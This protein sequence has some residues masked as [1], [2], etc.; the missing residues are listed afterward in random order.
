[1]TLPILV[2]ETNRCSP[3]SAQ[4]GVGVL[5]SAKYVTALRSR[6]EGNWLKVHI[7]PLILLKGKVV[8]AIYSVE[9]IPQDCL[10][11][12]IKTG[13]LTFG[14]PKL[15]PSTS[16]KISALYKILILNQ[17]RRSSEAS[18]GIPDLT[19]SC[20]KEARAA[21]NLNGLIPI[22]FDLIIWGNDKKCDSSVEQITLHGQNAL[23]FQPGAVIA[24]RYTDSQALPKYMSL[25]ELGK[26]PP[27]NVEFIKLKSIR[28]MILDSLD[29]EDTYVYEYLPMS[30]MEEPYEEKCIKQVR[31][32]VADMLSTLK[33]CRGS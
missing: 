31:E 25:I 16:K 20:K 29:V 19:A 32:K 18:D 5:V 12:L 14:D 23:S 26:N 8:V 1:M 21:E 9:H 4:T 33:L 13:N 22:H 2:S 11:E 7:E 15:D 30:Q 28:P 3:G 24:T 27:I 6:T 10:E 17:R